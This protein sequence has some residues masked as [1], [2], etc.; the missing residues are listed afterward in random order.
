MVTTQST[1]TEET[2]VR[3]GATG[4]TRQQKQG[5]AAVCNTD[6]CPGHGVELRRADT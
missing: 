1:L 5:T 2:S 6:E 3:T 4:A